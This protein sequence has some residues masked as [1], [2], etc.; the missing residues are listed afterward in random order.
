MQ[1]GITRPPR[2]PGDEV[3]RELAR[4]MLDGSRESLGRFITR[5]LSP[6]TH[7]LQHR[8][9]PDHSDLSGE[10]ARAT[11]RDA[12]RHLRAY[13]RGTASIPMPL[14]LIRRSESHIRKLAASRKRKA[15]GSGQS[16]AG[17]NQPG[18][19]EWLTESIQSMPRREATA[20]C[21]ALFEGLAPEE[22]AQAMG[23]SQTRAM[24]LLRAALL[25]VN[26]R[27]LYEES[28]GLRE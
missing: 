10:I 17:R 27:M 11:L 22:M 15:M 28:E 26:R 23:V 6:L 7:Y 24:R 18:T 9:G 8:L 25:R 19:A 4:G 3:D 2:S 1:I 5:H 21:L 16:A 14:W 20:L 12:A 13:A